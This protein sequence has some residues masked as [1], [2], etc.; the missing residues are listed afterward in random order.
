MTMCDTFLNVNRH[1]Q[2]GGHGRHGG[3]T[4]PSGRVVFARHV[5]T[6]RVRMFGRSKP[7]PTFEQRAFVNSAC[8]CARDRQT[9]GRPDRKGQGES[10]RCNTLRRCCA[11]FLAASRAA[12][13]FAVVDRI[14]DRS[15]RHH[16]RRPRRISCASSRG[17][18]QD[19]GKMPGAQG[20]PGN[21]GFPP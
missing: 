13:V 1:I 21:P 7:V 20:F 8:A 10:S 11:T 17:L 6:H 9:R 14:M 3:T 19:R 2:R 4:R 15:C 18:V 5:P 12:A 16:Q